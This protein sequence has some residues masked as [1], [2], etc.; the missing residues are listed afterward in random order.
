[1]VGRKAPLDTRGGKKA[2]PGRGHWLKKKRN[3]VSLPRLLK[4]LGT[5]PSF[6][7]KGGKGGEGR[8]LIQNRKYIN[9]PKKNTK[10]EGKKKPQN[11]LKIGNSK[12]RKK[13]SPRT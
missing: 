8:I 6:L 13:L 3:A 2:V 11:L 12:K 4:K 5:V 1:L 7:D 10:R 9:P